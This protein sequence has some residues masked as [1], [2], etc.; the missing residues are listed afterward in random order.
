VLAPPKPPSGPE[1]EL[2][3]REA[4][5]RKRKRWLRAAAILAV[6]AAGGLALHA[7]LADGS[8]KSGH[9]SG[10]SRIVSIPHCRS[11]QL[12]ASAA[13]AGV[14]TGHSEID[15]TLRNASDAACTLRGWARVQLVMS[16]DRLVVA[17]EQRI[18]NLT[19]RTAA[20]VPAGTVVLRPG[21]LG[22]FHLIVMNQVGRQGPEPQV[23]CAW[24]RAI[25]LTPPSGIGAPIRMHYSLSNCG[26]SV[27][28]VF[29]GRPNRYSFG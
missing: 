26:V 10:P 22:S 21:A 8:A 29:A 23:F 25:L 7:V 17:H 12:A 15:F 5:A 14:Y 11:D 6:V 19:R 24:S 2:L 4:R 27:S 9:G 18:R 20:V 13:G 1:L 28:P 3:I 16:G